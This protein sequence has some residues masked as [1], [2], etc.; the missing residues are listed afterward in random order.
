M[1]RYLVTGGAGFIGSHIVKALIEKGEQVRVLDNLKTGKEENISAYVHDIEWI[2]GDFTDL[3]VLKKAL[4][5]V[6]TVFHQGAIPSVPKSIN[7]PMDTNHANVTGTVQL[8][9]AAVEEKVSRVIYAASS[10]AYGD[11]EVLPKREDMLGKPMSP[12]AVSKYA[13]EH[14]C[15]AFHEIHGLETLS[16]RYFNV[17]GPKQDPYSEYSAVIPKFIHSVLRDQS[18]TIY[19]D[20]TQSRDFTY[21]DNVVSA[22]ILAAEA[23]HLSGEVINIGSGEQIDLNQLVSKINKKLGKEIKPTYAAERVGDVKH[24]LADI[25]R[26]EKLIGYRPNVSFTKGLD[27]TIE[28][29]KENK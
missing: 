7:E 17:F 28:W 8:L 18:P 19:G 26:A 10:S 1:A 13:G 14:Y 24:S 4:K 23:A 15:K 12:Y 20:G 11:S 25:T 29:F 6:D 2:E 22:N 16:L 9:Q 3:T 21:I 5:G 27:Q